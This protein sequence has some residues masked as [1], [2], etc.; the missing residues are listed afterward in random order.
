MAQERLALIDILER[1]GRV[2]QQADVNAWPLSVG[3]ALDCDLVLDDPHVAAR[4]GVLDLDA[5]GRLWLTVGETLNGVR[6]GRH[7]V[8]AGERHVLEPGAAPLQFGL[9][10]LRVRRAGEALAPEKPVT[11]LAT[12]RAVALTLLFT[13]LLWGATLAQQWVE[14][15]PGTPL[16]QWL[17][18]LLG[19][20][21]AIA[22]WCAAWALASK[23]FQHRFEF[24]VHWAHA[25]RWLLGLTALGWALNAAAS[26]LALPQL[27]RW[28]GVVELLL[29]A[30]WLWGHARL[31]LPAHPRGLAISFGAAAIGGLAVMMVLNLQREERLAGPL[32]MHQLPYAGIRWARPEPP[33][34]FVEHARGLKETLDRRARKDADEEAESEEFGS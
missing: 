21:G 8:G 29:A 11:G 2:R 18:A 14:S 22:L 15:D 33:Q 13:L 17:P 4:H 25:V 7:H 9:T 3:R 27:F 24:G 23:L 6:I 28:V 32:Y 1:D 26:A 20:P 16:T 12:P 31:V 5:D 30:V 19:L 10:R 34:A